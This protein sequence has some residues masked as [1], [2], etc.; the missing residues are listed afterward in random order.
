[1]SE[2]I[3]KEFFMPVVVLAFLI[4]GKYLKTNTRID[5]KFIPVILTFTGGLLGAIFFDD[6]SYVLTVAGL[7]GFS[8]NLH[9]IFKGFSNDIKEDKK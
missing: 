3:M 6:T 7:G 2:V 9:Q 4:F 1:M 5:N 8:N